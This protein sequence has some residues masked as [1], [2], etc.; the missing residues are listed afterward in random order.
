[1]MNFKIKYFIYLTIFLCT[2]GIAYGTT[3]QK[4]QDLNPSMLNTL[5]EQQHVYQK[6]LLQKHPII[7][8]LFSPQG[9]KFILY[10][11]KHAPL[12]APSL[13]QA[14]N[15][16]MATQVEHAAM[17]A[18]ELAIQGL[19][20][21]NTQFWQI[22]MLAFS[23]HIVLMQ[24]VIFKLNSSDSEKQLMQDLLSQTQQFLMNNLHQHN[25]SMD[26]TN[27]YAKAMKP[28]LLKLTKEVATAQVNHWMDIV[29]NWKKELGADWSNTYAVVIYIPVQP[30][31]NIFLNILSYFMGQEALGQR[32]FYFPLHN[33]TPT[34]NEA[35]SLFTKA[36]PDK[37][38]ANQVYGQ[39]FLSYSG[40]LSQVAREA[41]K[42]K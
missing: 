17:E 41:I 6:T 8:A 22:K 15:Y 7:V 35:L 40:I 21:S 38:L 34:A 1:M 19:N 4:F 42:Q 36:I 5:A 18:Y 29:S 31:N 2:I 37:D 12:I 13:E 9:G 11:P 20:D 25:L 3:I 39:Y 16:E 28:N 32:L 10:R 14:Q 30:Q 33:Y 24:Q 27:S 26:R 23:K